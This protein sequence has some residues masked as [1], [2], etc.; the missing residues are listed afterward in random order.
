MEN[1]IELGVV[2]E[3]KTC[4]IVSDASIARRL[5]KDGYR[6]IDIKPK[7]GHERE[8]IF[9]FAVEG[10]FMEVMGKYIQESKEKKEKN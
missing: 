5:L 4:K 3:Q 7:R 1:K 6:I 10:N 8:S 9:V 2:E